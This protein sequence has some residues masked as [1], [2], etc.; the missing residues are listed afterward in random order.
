MTK[1]KMHHQYAFAC[2]LDLATKMTDNELAAA[3]AAASLTVLEARERLLHFLNS[4][5]YR[6]ALS[7]EQLREAVGNLDTWALECVTDPRYRAESF[8]TFNEEPE[9]TPVVEL[10]HPDTDA[11]GAP[12]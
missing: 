9:V 5:D 12:F 10:C 2:E 8:L 3:I 11:D 7:R 1:K 6:S 4:R